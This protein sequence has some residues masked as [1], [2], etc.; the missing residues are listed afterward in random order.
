MHEYF[1]GETF[2]DAYDRALI[3]DLV[4]DHRYRAAGRGGKYDHQLLKKDPANLSVVEI[5]NQ[6]EMKQAHRQ[7]ILCR[8]PALSR[9][10]CILNIPTTAVVGDLIWAFVRGRALYALRPIGRQ[11]KHYIFIGECYVH[12][13]MDGE[14]DRRLHAGEVKL[15]QIYLV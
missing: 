3:L 13:L 12:G 7:A 15:E 9:K 4:F 6:N 2:N 1:T 11:K 10:H 8:H 5:K 14:L